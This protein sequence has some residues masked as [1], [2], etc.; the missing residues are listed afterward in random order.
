[1]NFSFKKIVKDHKC[2]GVNVLRYLLCVTDSFSETVMIVVGAKGQKWKKIKIYE[3]S[4]R[5]NAKS[6]REM[7]KKKIC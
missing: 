4:Q 5:L 2:V 1:M 6:K 3:M 7:I